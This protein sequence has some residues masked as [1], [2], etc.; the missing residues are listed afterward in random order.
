[1]GP[2]ISCGEHRHIHRKIDKIVLC[3]HIAAINIYDI[4]QDLECIKLI[5]TGRATFRSGMER[6]VTALKFPIKKSA[7]LQ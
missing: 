3:R 5:P 6:P 4:A 1:M 2:A 7:Y